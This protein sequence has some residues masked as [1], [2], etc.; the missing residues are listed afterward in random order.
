MSFLLYRIGCVCFGSRAVIRVQLNFSSLMG[1][2]INRGSFPLIRSTTLRCYGF[3][4]AYRHTNSC[5]GST[6]IVLGC[7]CGL[8]QP[9]RQSSSQTASRLAGPPASM[10]CF[11]WWPLGRPSKPTPYI[12]QDGGRLRGLE[13][14]VTSR[15][16]RQR[17][18]TVRD[19]IDPRVVLTRSICRPCERTVVHLSVLSYFGLSL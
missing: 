4:R 8:G 11:E 1:F 16:G 14:A 2:H 10:P 5:R 15:K 7:G 13:A 9:T 19:V 18:E 12:I 6:F 3:V 17:D